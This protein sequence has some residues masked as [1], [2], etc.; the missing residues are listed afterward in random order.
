[1]KKKILIIGPFSVMGGREVEANLII[2]SL[3][4]NYK[5]SILSTK[6]YISPN[7]KS[8]FKSVSVF[9]VNC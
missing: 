5:I 3:K 6:D 2:E 4:E 8:F 9:V 7:V 1:M